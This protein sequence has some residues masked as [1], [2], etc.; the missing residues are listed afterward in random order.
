[1][2]STT[3][4][5]ANEGWEMSGMKPSFSLIL[6]W[7][8]SAQFCRLDGISR[9]SCRDAF[10]SLPIFQGLPSGFAYTP[11]PLCSHSHEA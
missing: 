5:T 8:V 11:N 3:P 1:M 7:L 2:H 6:L 9:L 10:G 4:M